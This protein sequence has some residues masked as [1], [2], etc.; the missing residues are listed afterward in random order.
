MA[1]YST[2][3]AAHEH[4]SVEVEEEEELLSYFSE[5][6]LDP[7]HLATAYNEHGEIEKEGER[8]R[9]EKNNGKN[10]IKKIDDSGELESA[11]KWLGDRMRR[12]REREGG[13]EGKKER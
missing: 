12:S 7:R 8:G 3:L 5:V 2:A 10:K 6:K 13:R 9:Q 1:T 11:S 4:I